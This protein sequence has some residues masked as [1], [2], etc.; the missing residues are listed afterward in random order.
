M[1]RLQALIREGFLGR[2]PIHA[3]KSAKPRIIASLHFSTIRADGRHLRIFKD[4]VYE[5]LTIKAADSL[6][7]EASRHDSNAVDIGTGLDC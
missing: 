3:A 4:L 7:P 5:V 6:A 1:S 2:S